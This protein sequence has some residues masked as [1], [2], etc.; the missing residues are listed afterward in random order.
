M[1]LSPDEQEE[2]KAVVAVLSCII[3][4]LVKTNNDFPDWQNVSKFHASKPPTI[5]IFDYF[6]RIRKYASCSP[7]SFILALIYIDRLIQINN[8]A[9]TTLN[10]HRV[11]ISSV[12]IAAKFFDD[13]FYN[14]EYF[15]RVGGVP[16]SEINS[17]EVE[18]LFKINFSLHVT[19]ELYLKYFSELN[20]HSR[21]GTCASCRNITFPSIPKLIDR[22]L[23]ISQ[24]SDDNGD[25]N[26]EENDDTSC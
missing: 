10:V 19:S 20:Q 16:C 23:T 2:K 4:R 1:E 25:D 14:N 8:F 22:R 24:F 6:E 12:L 3:D 18:F 15:A 7:E 11:I 13:H 5:S 17:L 26:D 9:L 21:N